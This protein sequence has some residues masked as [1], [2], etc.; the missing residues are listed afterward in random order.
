VGQYRRIIALLLGLGLVL[1]VAACRDE[2]LP[3]PK[4]YGSTPP[5]TSI[6]VDT[7]DPDELAEGADRVF[8]FPVPRAMRVEARFDDTVYLVGRVPFASLNNYIRERVVPGSVDTGPAK[9]VYNKAVLKTNA[10]RIL[11][12]AVSNDYGSIELVIR[13][14]SRPPAERGISEDERWRRAGLT[15]DGRVIEKKAE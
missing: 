1:A 7:A 4:S 2:P 14:R 8:G 15:P 9:T 11:E 3:P 6:P 5:P 12:L 10:K 13:N